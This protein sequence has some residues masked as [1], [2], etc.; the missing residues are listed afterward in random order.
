MHE[1]NKGV[2]LKTK[3]R[4]SISEFYDLEMHCSCRSRFS[5]ALQDKLSL[6]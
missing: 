3:L 2:F 4:R 1:L 6:L 5:A